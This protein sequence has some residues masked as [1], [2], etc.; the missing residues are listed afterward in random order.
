MSKSQ[1]KLKP[2][3]FC[4][5]SDIKLNYWDTNGKWCVFC[6]NNRCRINPETYDYCRKA[7]AIKAW[8]RR[9]K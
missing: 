8:N 2:C 6:G 4:G 3:P 9:A 5:S 1:E 7:E